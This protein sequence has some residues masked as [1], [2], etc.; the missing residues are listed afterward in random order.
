MPNL[1]RRLRD[2]LRDDP[3]L[4][5]IL[6]IFLAFQLIAMT[7]DL[8]GSHGWE[9]DGIA[10]RDL[11]GGLAFNLTPGK[12]HRYPLL[13]YV[14]VALGSLPALLFGAAQAPSTALPDLTR[15]TLQPPVMTWVSV[16][17]KL[18][19]VGM[20]AGVIWTLARITRRLFSAEAARWTAL[21]VTTHFAFAYY[22]RTSNLD[23]PYLFWGVLAADRLLTVAE[24][25][26]RRDYITFGLLVAASVA[27]K[28]Q[29]YAAWT[30]TGPLLLIALPLLRPQ[31]LAAGRAHW[32]RLPWA[33]GAGVL[34]LGVL[35]GA[36]LN[37]TGFITRLRTLT[38]TNSQDWRTYAPGWEGWLANAQD[39]LAF[40]AEA[41]W[42]WPVM[43]LIWAGIPLIL[44]TRSDRPEAPLQ[45]PA[46]RAL[47]LGIAASSL[48]SFTLV[49][50]RTGHRFM[51]PAGVWLAVAGGVAIA[52]AI[53]RLGP[54]L[55][56]FTTAVAAALLSLAFA[57]TLTLTLTQRG[58][59]RHAVEDALD[60]LPRGARV[61][62]Y[63]LVVYLPHFRGALDGRY[64]LQR[65]DPAP[66]NKRNPLLGAQEIQAPYMGYDARRPDAIVIPEAFAQRFLPELTD[67]EGPRTLSNIVHQHQANAD[68]AAFFQRALSDHLPGY[69]VA[70]VAEPQLPAWAVWLG[71]TPRV[72]HSGTGRRVWVLIRDSTPPPATTP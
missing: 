61:E 63:G 10:P 26:T 48:L 58:D 51:L 68:G 8:P 39:I 21:L 11:F 9:N 46:W 5:A 57:N 25:G 67:P 15:A 56:P 20:G 7:W 43:V 54:A 24:R 71:A 45:H 42:P 28:D 30:L 3:A 55:Q 4:T 69:H 52:A 49:V 38:G 44:L 62:T 13:H 22:A 36:F 50:G 32:R 41:W 34:G 18:L 37:P 27:T 66:P 6:L 29:A 14:L 33:V 70:L 72:I 2:A 31:A 23:V 17:A 35:G 53:K 1:L 40:Q 47:P 65:V 60:R 16:V 19:S 64:Q 59:A 12:G